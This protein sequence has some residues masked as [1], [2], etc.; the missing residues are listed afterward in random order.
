MW[1][2]SRP[3]RG[4]ALS[5]ALAMADSFSPHYEADAVSR[6]GEWLAVIPRFTRE[7]LNAELAEDLARALDNYGR[8]PTL[9]EDGTLLD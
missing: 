8:V 3:G 1:G 7:P 4:N 9:A 2:A 6:P 5:I